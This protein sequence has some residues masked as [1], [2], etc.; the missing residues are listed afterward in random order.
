[1]NLENISNEVK[2]LIGN[3]VSKNLS[4]ILPTCIEVDTDYGPQNGSSEGEYLDDY[5]IKSIELEEDESE[6]TIQVSA[7]LDL[8]VS[9]DISG[10]VHGF[11]EPG[12]DDPCFSTNISFKINNVKI[13]G[14]LYLEDDEIDS[15]DFNIDSTGTMS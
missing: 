9:V 15:Y 8:E 11:H 1:M 12:E 3:F 13:S 7:I 5:T 10:D 4:S 2:D 14:N 6:N